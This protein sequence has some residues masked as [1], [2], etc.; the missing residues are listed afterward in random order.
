MIIT[1]CQIDA[2]ELIWVWGEQWYGS[3]QLIYCSKPK[4]KEKSI[5]KKNLQKLE[6]ITFCLRDDE[7]WILVRGGQLC[8]SFPLIYCLSPE[9]KY[10]FLT[11]IRFSEYN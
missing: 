1:V 4:I 2:V 6:K 9:N 11:Q 10:I 7:E 3:F 8:G 5:I